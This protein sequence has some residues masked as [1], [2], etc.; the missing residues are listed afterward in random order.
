MQSVAKSGESLAQRFAQLERE[1][2]WRHAY[3]R[4]DLT[5]D[6]DELKERA[7]VRVGEVD[8]LAGRPVTS[9]ERLDGVKLNLAD[10]AWLL[11]R[12]S[13]TEPLLRIYCEAPDEAAVAATLVA[14]RDLVMA[15]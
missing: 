11:V 10:D 15:S 4:L 9:V 12:P 8:A 3:D 5:L 7:L 14:A 1:V 2:G 13:G 6:S